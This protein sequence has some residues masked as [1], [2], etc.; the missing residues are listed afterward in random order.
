M[1]AVFIF[2][3]FFHLSIFWGAGQEGSHKYYSRNPSI[4]KRF[5]VMTLVD[6]SEQMI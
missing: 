5:G 3:Y 1:T 6:K 2:Q 4:S